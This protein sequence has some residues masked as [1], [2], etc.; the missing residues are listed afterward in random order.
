MTP[1]DGAV[2]NSGCIN[3]S[4]PGQRPLSFPRLSEEKSSVFR[5]PENTEEE[6]K[7]DPVDPSHGG[8]AELLAEA[9]ECLFALK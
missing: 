9:A 4:Q 2:S 5:R 3:L 1:C 6:E 8:S 7:E